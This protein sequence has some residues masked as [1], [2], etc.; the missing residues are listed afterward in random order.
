MSESQNLARIRQQYD[1]GP[2]TPAVATK[3]TFEGSTDDDVV[4][5]TVGEVAPLIE[6]KQ[7]QAV[8]C[9]VDEKPRL[10]PIWC[11]KRTGKERWAIYFWFRVFEPAEH[12]GTELMMYVRWNPAWAVKGIDY[13][14]ALWKAACVAAGRRLDKKEKISTGLFRG[15]LFLCQLR[16]AGKKKSPAKYTV[17]DSLLEKITG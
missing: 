2:K 3:A 15:K 10:L 5:G 9:K 12:A 11:D 7:V 4:I 14:S 17:I 16:L 6:C 1:L 8:C 13:R